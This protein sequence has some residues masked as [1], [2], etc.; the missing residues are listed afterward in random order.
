MDYLCTQ[1]TAFKQLL[2]IYARNDGTRANIICCGHR[3]CCSINYTRKVYPPSPWKDSMDPN[4]LRR[5]LAAPKKNRQM[6][7]QAISMH[8]S[9]CPTRERLTLIVQQQLRPSMSRRHSWCLV[10]DFGLISFAALLF[11]GTCTADFF[12]RSL[13][14][15]GQ[16]RCCRHLAFPKTGSPDRR[17]LR[18]SLRTWHFTGRALSN[19]TRVWQPQFASVKFQSVFGIFSA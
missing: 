15:L 1:Q 5:G 3:S 14:Q 9:Q 7:L 17:R 18:S 8:K 4:C 6:S 12:C 11:L 2:Y 19:S 13:L 10:P 16:T